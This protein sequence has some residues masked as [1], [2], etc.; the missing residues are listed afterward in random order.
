[1]S[2]TARFG[3]GVHTIKSVQK[4][5]TWE[6]PH[7]VVFRKRLTEDI[8]EEINKVITAYHVCTAQKTEKITCH[9]EDILKME[10]GVTPKQVDTTIGSSKMQE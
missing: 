7:L 10:C 2:G 1:M 4:L 8:F 6:K 5:C 3:T 9:I